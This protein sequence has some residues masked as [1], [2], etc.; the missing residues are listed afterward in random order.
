MVLWKHIVIVM[1]CKIQHVYV[2]ME[3]FCNFSYRSYTSIEIL[4]TPSSLQVVNIY[5]G[6]LFYVDSF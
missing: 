2:C 4:I 6:Y 5:Q 1:C 3:D